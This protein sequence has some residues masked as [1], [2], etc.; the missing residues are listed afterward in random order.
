M[1]S[2][3]FTVNFIDNFISIFGIDCGENGIDLRLDAIGPLLG[4]RRAH[5][6]QQRQPPYLP[7]ELQKLGLSVFQR[8]A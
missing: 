2:G 7:Q 4:L 5:I 8:I 6:K 1:A 3:I